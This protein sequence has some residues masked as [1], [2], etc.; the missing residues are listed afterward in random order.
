MR[1]QVGL[2]TVK[3]ATIRPFGFAD[4]NAWADVQYRFD[5]AEGWRS[6]LDRPMVVLPNV[7][8]DVR[9]D[10]KHAFRGRIEDRVL[11]E[12]GLKLSSVE[13]LLLVR[14]N[15]AKRVHIIERMSVDSAA[16]FEWS[17]P[18]DIC[19]QLSNGRRIEF[20]FILATRTR[21]SFRGVEVK[22]YGRLAK[23][24]VVVSSESQ[25]VSFNFIK[26]SAEDF[27]VKGLP[28]KTAWHLDVS[29]P[30]VL[31]EEC[32]DVSQ[33]LRVFVHEDAWL[34]LQEIRSG[35]PTGEAIGTFFIA[36]LVEAILGLAA[37]IP[38]LTREQIVEGSV[39]NR[40]LT[41][42]SNQQAPL[43]GMVDIFMDQGG[44]H[45]LGAHVQDAVKLT[46]SLRRLHLEG[47]ID[48]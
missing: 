23:H 15:F 39:L 2:K 44:F 46:K 35:D 8:Q 3:N 13:L 33:V 31:I 17:V 26:A 45:A 47:G 16:E 5:P 41:W 10:A 30:R 36:A 27:E 24:E 20:E 28:S 37:G 22:P 7:C 48:E 1:N 11:V 6:V 18:R 32:D 4:A 43:D 40:I 38:G 25:G 42:V 14:D 34:E 19:E 29:D 21:A 12:A 9:K